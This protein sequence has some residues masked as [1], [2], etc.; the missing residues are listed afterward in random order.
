MIFDRMGIV[1]L[2]NDIS[3]S[4]NL[5]LY[6]NYCFI[7]PSEKSDVI[8]FIQLGEIKSVYDITGSEVMFNLDGGDLDI[9]ITD[10]E[11]LVRIKKGISL[12]GYVCKS[13]ILE[14]E[15]SEGLLIC[16]NE[17]KK[18]FYYVPN[19]EVD[20]RRREVIPFE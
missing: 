13:E 19:E 11:R 16:I 1:V 14:E 20:E 12:S 10:E 5:C 9:C 6:E 4:G 15:F 7:K 8:C 17:E 2:S 3:I 18:I